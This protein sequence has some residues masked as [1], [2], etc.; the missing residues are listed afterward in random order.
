VILSISSIEDDAVLLDRAQ[1][2]EADLVLVHQLQRLLV[3]EEPHWA[4]RIGNSRRLRRH[5]A[6]VGEHPLDLPA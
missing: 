2:L 1:R 6:H 5:A 3:R 4:S